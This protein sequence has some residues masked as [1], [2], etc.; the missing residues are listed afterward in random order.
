MQ[1]IDIHTHFIPGIDDGATSIQ[2][3]VEMLR[4]AYEAGTRGLVAT[5]HMFLDGYEKNDIL[6]VN[7]RFAATLAALKEHS[8]EPQ[9]AFIREM[10][11][12]LGSENYASIEFLDAMARGC[13]IPINSGRYLLVEFSP[14]LPLNKIEMVL[15]KVLQSGYLPVVAH[16]ERVVA[17]QENP[18]RLRDLAVMGCFFQVNG[19]SFLDSANP[20]LRKTSLTLAK[21]G[22]IHVV[23]SD[24]HRPARRPPV[25]LDVSRI[26]QQ[27]YPLETVHTWLHDNPE[28]IVENLQI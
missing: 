11:L 27:K 22:F 8:E 10:G 13:V 7:D 9:N 26:L 5:P 20:R 19:E 14:F 3:T 24:G 17:V 1:F 23:A 4:V 21:E 18:M 28:R 15:Q 16:T 12:F 2:E 25:L 6:A